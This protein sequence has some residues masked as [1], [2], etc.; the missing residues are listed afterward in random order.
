M[1]NLEIQIQS[2][3]SS[4]VYGM[5]LSLLYN[6]MYKYLYNNNFFIKIIFN[7]IYV[8]INSLLY[9]FILILISEGN[10]HIY[11]IIMLAIGFILGN[12]KTKKIRTK[13]AVRKIKSKDK[14]KKNN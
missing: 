11:F 8:A 12:R 1:M 2:L 4:L 9:F 6:L 13:P 7:I 5:Y 3:V 10:I 14:K